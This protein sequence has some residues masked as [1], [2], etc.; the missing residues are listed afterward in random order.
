MHRLQAIHVSAR[1]FVPRGVR[2][3]LSLHGLTHA[4]FSER[5][6]DLFTHSS[7]TATHESDVALLKLGRHFRVGPDS[8]IVLGRNAQENAR[9]AAFEDADRWLI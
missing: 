7:E 2:R 4:R 3:R 1:P 5:L 9:L 6:R 8:K